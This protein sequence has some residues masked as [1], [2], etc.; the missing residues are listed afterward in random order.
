MLIQQLREFIIRP[1]LQITDL[2]SK[3]AENLLIMTLCAET[4]G[5]YFKQEKGNALGIFQI[6]IPTLK[7]VIHTLNHPLNLKLNERVLAACFYSVH[8]SPDALIHNL[9]YATLI[10][11]IIYWRDTQSLPREDDIPRLAEYYV[12][13]YNAGGKATVERAIKIY[14]ELG[15]E[16]SD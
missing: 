12:K 2:W 6:E 4:Q 10:A 1:T 3:A 16:V 5:I 15:D 13:Y 8:P 14:K 9:R 7:S 11:R